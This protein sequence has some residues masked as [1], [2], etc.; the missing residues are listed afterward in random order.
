MCGEWPPYGR[1]LGGSLD[2][3][4]ASGRSF[5]GEFA[6]RSFMI[7]M[8]KM[9]GIRPN[10]LVAKGTCWIFTASGAGRVYTQTHIVKGK[11]HWMDRQI[12]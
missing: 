2:D 7:W 1:S 4:R 11:G 3:G 9:T 6:S 10:K 8:G 5:A 12:R